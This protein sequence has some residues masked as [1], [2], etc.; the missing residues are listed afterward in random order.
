MVRSSP[1]FDE[2]AA[3]GNNDDSICVEV[4]AVSI[5][6]TAWKAVIDEYAELSFYN[7]ATK[8]SVREIPGDLAGQLVASTSETSFS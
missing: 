1:L 6:G 5:A 8:E 7:T 4:D 2:S 3:P